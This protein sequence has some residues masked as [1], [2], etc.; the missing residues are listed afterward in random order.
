MPYVN[1]QSTEVMKHS[2]NRNEESD[3]GLEDLQPINENVH[4]ESKSKIFQQNN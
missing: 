1:P 3:K 2:N 4:E